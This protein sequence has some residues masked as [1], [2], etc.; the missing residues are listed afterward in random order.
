MTV[1]DMGCGS[2]RLPAALG[3]GGIKVEY[4]GVD[5]VQS[6]LDYAAT[7]SPGHYRFVLHRELSTPLPDASV[8]IACVFSV[9]THLLHQESFIYLQELRRVTRPG[10]LVLFSFLEFDSQPLADLRADR[11]RPA[12]HA[13]AGPQPVHRAQRDRGVGRPSRFHCRAPGGRQRRPR[14][15]PA[16][17]VFGNTQ[18]AERQERDRT[19]W[20]LKVGRHCEEPLS[21]GTTQSHTR[22]W[23]S[24]LFCRKRSSQ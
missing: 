9:F 4:V 5:I 12:E 1:L 11:R 14:R 24:G 20:K 22:G 13:K 17:A 3:T 18:G 6:L 8:D 7:R 10:G 15:R 19:R 16:R 21:V 23:C 2:G